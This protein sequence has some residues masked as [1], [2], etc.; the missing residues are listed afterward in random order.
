MLLTEFSTKFDV[1]YNNIL[2]DQAP[3]MNSYEKSV[4]LTDA[5]YAVVED[6]YRGR[7]LGTSFDDTEDTRR[8]LSS[9]ISQ[10]SL[11][12]AV[13]VNNTVIPDDD[14]E[15]ICFK[16]PDDVLFITYESA[17][18]GGE[19]M[20]CVSGKKFKEASVV[21]CPQDNFWRTVRSPFRG[22]NSSRVLKLEGVDAGKNVRIAE[23]VSKYPVLSYSARYIRRPKPIILEDLAENYGEGVSIEGITA[24]TECELPD[25]IHREIL[26]RAVNMAKAIWLSNLNTNNNDR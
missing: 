11:S 14:F 4:V 12:R 18:I 21:P 23:L 20:Y 9:L 1:F 24:A 5:E 7:S 25:A 3:G 19:E 15:K 13:A 8:Y 2:S 22:P 10:V 26:L 17:A 6:I 16:L